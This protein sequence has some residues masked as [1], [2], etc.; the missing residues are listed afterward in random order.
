MRTA[1]EGFGCRQAL[2]AGKQI[3]LATTVK[4]LGWREG[5]TYT[6]AV[7]IFCYVLLKIISLS[8]GWHIF[9]DLILATVSGWQPRAGRG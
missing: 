5:L 1:P 4:M 8:I 6:Q 9:T 7:S 2:V 3:H